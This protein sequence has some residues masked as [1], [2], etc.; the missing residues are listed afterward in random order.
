MPEFCNAILAQ[1][2]TDLSY[3]HTLTQTHT[4][5]TNIFSGESTLAWIRIVDV[6]YQLAKK[7]HDMNNHLNTTPE[8]NR[9][10]TRIPIYALILHISMLTC[11]ETRIQV[12]KQSQVYC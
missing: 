11:V 8:C 1:K 6:G 9:Q 3:M 2:N 12:M 10:T 4:V 5:S 7:F